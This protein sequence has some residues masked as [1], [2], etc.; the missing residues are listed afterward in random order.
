MNKIIDVRLTSIF[1]PICQTLIYETL[2]QQQ[3]QSKETGIDSCTELLIVRLDGVVIAYGTFELIDNIN[4][5][6]NSLH[7]RNIIKDHSLAEYWLSRQLKRHLR[8][9]PYIKFLLSS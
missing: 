2:C 6:I 5:S 9:T 3:V 1:S 4:M 8:N 7:F